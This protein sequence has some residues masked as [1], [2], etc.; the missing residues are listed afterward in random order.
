MEAPTPA[1]VQNAREIEKDPPTLSFKMLSESSDRLDHGT[2]DR[3]KSLVYA[4]I[5]AQDLRQEREDY[6]QETLLY[7][8]QTMKK[9]PGQR[10]HSYLGGCLFFIRDRLKRGKSL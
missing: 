8:W 1:L 10:L 4:I 5:R 9:N 7:F 3:I 2:I 6:L